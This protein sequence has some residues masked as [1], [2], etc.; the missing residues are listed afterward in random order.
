MPACQPSNLPAWPKRSKSSLW[1]GAEG[2]DAVWVTS[3]VLVLLGSEEQAAK[4][5]SGGEA[6]A[7]GPEVDLEHSREET[8]TERGK[9]ELH[10]RSAAHRASNSTGMSFLSLEVYKLKPSHHL[11]GMR[12][13]EYLPWVV[14]ALSG[15]EITL[16]P[17]VVITTDIMSSC[18]P[19]LGAHTT[20]TVLQVGNISSIFQMLREG[21]WPFPGPHSLTTSSCSHTYAF[22]T[23]NLA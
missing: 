3:S 2:G 23:L 22:A 9:C 15:M 14:L 5:E 21:Q 10:R 6:A 1:G 7:G 17:E 4:Q 20:P 19:A 16:I 13:E 12:C 11:P 18:H 8:H